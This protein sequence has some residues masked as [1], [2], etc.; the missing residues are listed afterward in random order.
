MVRGDSPNRVANALRS[1]GRGAIEDAL[2]DAATELFSARP[3][4]TASI[5]EI[6]RQA[7]VPHSTI[8]RY[9]G[10]KQELLRDAIRRG[11][12]ETAGALRGMAELS[13]DARLTQALA[14]APMLSML[15]LASIEGSDPVEFMADPL[16]ALSLTADYSRGLSARAEPAEGPTY[17]ARILVAVMMAAVMTWQA[18]EGTI[19]RAADL[20]AEDP[21]SVHRQVAELLSN[22]LSLAR[23]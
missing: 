1:S 17:D 21:E 16:G 20:A 4:S 19:L 22:L 15:V 2:V 10:S 7:G 9:F 3:P 13:P 11:G 6:A 14:Q 23:A 5:R 12:D 18:A 8:H